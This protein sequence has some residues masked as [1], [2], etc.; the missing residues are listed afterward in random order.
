MA[1][2]DFFTLALESRFIVC[3]GKSATHEKSTLA[4][5]LDSIGR[6]EVLR[7]LEYT[8]LA[9]DVCSLSEQPYF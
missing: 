7:G 5:V 1:T 3:G 9:L 4:Q 6:Y 2:A 8:S